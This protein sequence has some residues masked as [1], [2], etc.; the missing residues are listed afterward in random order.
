MHFVEENEA[1]ATAEIQR[2]ENEIDELQPCQPESLADLGLSVDYLPFFSMCD[3]KM[4]NFMV[5]NRCAS[6]C[7]FC[8][9]TWKKMMKRGIKTIMKRIRACQIALLHLILR[10]V[11]AFFFGAVRHNAGVLKYHDALTA[12][13]KIN[14]AIWKQMIEEELAKHGLPINQRRKDTGGTYNDG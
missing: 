7:P 6:T 3:G 12:D 4:I 14:I 5:G 11:E 13:D 1:N 2:L 10:G 8:L 9:A